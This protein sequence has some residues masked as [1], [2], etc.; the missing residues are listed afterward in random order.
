MSKRCLPEQLKLQQEQRRA[1]TLEAIQNAIA[2]IK[3]EGGI[4]TKKKLIE[5]T[6]L[7]NSTFSKQHVKELLEINKVC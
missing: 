3:E 6:G 2:L 4:V 5:I 7:S 1:A